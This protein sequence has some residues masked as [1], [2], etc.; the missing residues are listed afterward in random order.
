MDSNLFIQNDLLKKE[1]E[2]L[3]LINSKLIGENE[4]L[5]LGI[6]LVKSELQKKTEYHRNYFQNVSK[7]KTRVC[8]VCNLTILAG[9]YGNHLKSKSHLACALA[10]SN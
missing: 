8:E 7:S 1:V 9:S 10:S 6:E 5:L 4:L 3:K 2:E